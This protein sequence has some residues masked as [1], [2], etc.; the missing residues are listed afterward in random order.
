MVLSPNYLTPRTKCVNVL[1]GDEI[2]KRVSVAGQR[3]HKVKAVRPP[4]NTRPVLARASP[5]ASA[6]F[7]IVG[8]GASAG[9]LDACKRLVNALPAH[10]GI[11]FILVQ[12]LDPTH[13]SM[14]ADLLATH[15]AMTVVQATD[16][17]LVEPDHL[18]IIPPA[19]YLAMG[20][21]LLHL[22]QPLAPHGARLPARGQSVSFSRAPEPTAASA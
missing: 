6:K 5:D 22:S 18:Y 10:S 9:G 7:P 14:M 19:T 16:G 12:H 20:N 17:M 11:A 3:R 8:I 4:S 2:L 13:Q 1:T 15:T 21:G